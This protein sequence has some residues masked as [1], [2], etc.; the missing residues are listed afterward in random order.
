MKRV[1]HLV[2]A[3]L[4][5]VLVATPMCYVASIKPK[6]AILYIVVIFQENVSFDHYFATYPYALNPQGEPKFTAL[7]GSPKVEGLSGD[8]LTKNPN[9]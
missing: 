2:G 9:F 7:P 3:V 1:G 8:L 5:S 4:T 6:E